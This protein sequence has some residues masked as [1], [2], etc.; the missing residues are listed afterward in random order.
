MGQALRTH[1]A[2][3]TASAKP[4]APYKKMVL[5][6][7]FSRV[8]RLCR[9]IC[10]AHA[11]LLSGKLLSRREYACNASSATASCQHPLSHLQPICFRLQAFKCALVACI[12]GIGPNPLRPVGAHSVC[13]HKA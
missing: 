12:I 11:R 5:P 13:R 3:M 6:M 1:A 7:S 9:T 2:P 10:E 8:F 4:A